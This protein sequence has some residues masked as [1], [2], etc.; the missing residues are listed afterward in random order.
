MESLLDKLIILLDNETALYRSLHH[1]IEKEKIAVMGADADAL[2]TLNEEKEILLR[3]ARL[4]ERQRCEVI[5]RLAGEMN[6][7]VREVTLNHLTRLAPEPWASRLKT[8]GA[9]LRSLVSRVR[10]LNNGNRNLIRLSLEFVRS[11]LTLLNNMMSGASRY[12]RTGKMYGGQNN[13]KV[14]R[15]VV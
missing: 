14:L 6:R 10:Q 13:G 8:I 5:A 1:V 9:D 2:I 15:G 7:P 11:S 4:L 12:C 3:R